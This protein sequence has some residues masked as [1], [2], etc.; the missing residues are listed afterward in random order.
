[1]GELL[2]TYEAT[3]KLQISR[4]T[5]SR[6]VQ[7][8][9]I[10]IAEFSFS[11]THR[12][13]GDEIVAAMEKLKEEEAQYVTYQ[14]VANIL[15]VSYATAVRYHSQGYFDSVE[16]EKN[17]WTIFRRED[18]M[19]F[20][21]SLGRADIENLFTSKEIA[22]LAGV[23]YQFFCSLVKDGHIKPVRKLPSGRSYFT[24]D[25]IEIILQHKKLREAQNN[26]G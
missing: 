3:Q 13:D 20:S 8:G 17:G 25:A 15:G 14:Q 23:E 12:Y 16:N 21:E 19:K 26:E 10:P 1:M 2:S 5:F 18:I 9:K 22:E 7:Q 4:T 6:L 24:G 11:G